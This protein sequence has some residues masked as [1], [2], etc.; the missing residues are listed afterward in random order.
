MKYLIVAFAIVLVSAKLGFDASAGPFTSENMACMK[1]SGL[2]YAIFRAYR[3]YG[4]V[5]PAAVANIKAAHD[6]G[7]N[8]VDVYIFPCFKCNNPRKQIQDMVKALS[9]SKYNWIWIDIERFAWG[10]KAANRKFITEMLDEAPKHGKPIGV[11]TNKNEWNGIVGI[12][13]TLGS[14][15]PL[16][17]AYWNYKPTREDFQPFAGWKKCL[18][19]QYDHNQH[20]CSVVYDLNYKD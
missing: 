1:K 11:Y 14:K 12:D 3:S 8:D 15:F 10:E 4:V 7:I 2:V 16:W 19:K 6:G 9:G 18:I 20:K 17:W 5:D 13:F